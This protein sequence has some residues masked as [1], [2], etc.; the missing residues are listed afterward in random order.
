MSIGCAYAKSKKM[1]VVLVVP[2]DVFAVV[3]PAA[4]EQHVHLAILL[5]PFRYLRSPALPDLVVLLDVNETL[6]FGLRIREL[7]RP[8][9]LVILTPCRRLWIGI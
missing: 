2:R 9:H 3:V 7:L 5:S 6:A 1:L 4:N 8:I